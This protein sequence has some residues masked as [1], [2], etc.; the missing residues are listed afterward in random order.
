MVALYRSDQHAEALASYQEARR[1]LGEQ[2]GIEP[3]AALRRLEEQILLEE[4]P[5]DLPRADAVPTQS[6]PV[7]TSVFVG[8]REETA[9]VE[10]L[11][12]ENRLVTLTGMGGVGKTSLAIEV[13]RHL[14]DVYPDRV[15]LVE[16]ASV[17]DPDQAVVEIAR[18]FNV[19]GR[20]TR[21]YLESVVD[22]LA[23][24]NLLLILDNC[25]HVVASAA[26]VSDALL[27][28]CPG[29]DILATSRQPLHIAGEQA[30][31]VPP[32]AVP[33]DDLE[34]SLA[35]AREVESVALFV[36][37]AGR[38]RASFELDE[39]NV[40]EVAG[41]CR[42]LDGIPLALE[43]AAARIAVLSP[44]QIL[45]RLDDRFA[46]LTHGPQTQPARQQTLR[47]TMEWSHDLLSVE[48]QTLL[49]RLSVFH[50]GFTLEAAE[51]ICA[52]EL[53]DRGAILDLVGRLVDTSLLTV[54]AGEQVR[55]GML[56]TVRHYALDRLGDTTE[57]ASLQ[58]HHAQ[59]YATLATLGE[60]DMFS[61][62]RAE[63]Y[64]QLTSEEANL[65]AGLEWALNSGEAD[66]LLRMTAALSLNWFVHNRLDEASY[67]LPKALEGASPE[68]TAQRAEALYVLGMIYAISYR[69]EE[70]YEVAQQLA[71]VAEALTDVEHAGEAIF[72]REI[73]AKTTGDLREAR[74]LAEKQV[75]LL[76]RGD[77]PQASFALGERC[78][79]LR[80]ARRRRERLP[81][82]G[83]ERRPRREVLPDPDPR[84]DQ[85]RTRSH[86]PPSGRPSRGRTPP[87][88]GRR[89]TSPPRMDPCANGIPRPTGRGRHGHEQ[90]RT[91]R[92]LGSGSW[93]LG[94][95]AP[96]ARSEGGEPDPARP[97]RSPAA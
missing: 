83:R 14:F 17:S 13:A 93:R 51:T 74:R 55:Y 91:S 53:L 77:H 46:L 33:P 2:L 43:L 50:G 94:R 73:C 10:E 90:A 6:L 78:A 32:L 23:P 5:L 67:W 21:P 80:P 64:Q 59:Y 42:R 52:D 66:L 26:D 63:H 45:D 15:W 8:R 75:L 61:E 69:R 1:V 19:A 41:I 4:L 82:R 44:G 31:P 40:D 96:R 3:N 97:H 7:R 86:R 85:R 54:R 16:L 79:P 89:G 60:D 70:A 57:A 95:R 76:R 25:E 28:A 20:G 24:R 18:T 11:V 58:R 92:N 29:L 68:P 62:D 49:R 9:R 27:R 65:R 84:P 22:L 71:T 88:P 56:D 87:L 38:A 48:E 36:E 72:I 30:W 47:A 81:I 35:A 39:S 34:V 37:R 12:G